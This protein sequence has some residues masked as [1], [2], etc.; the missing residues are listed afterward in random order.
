MKNNYSHINNKNL[1]IGTKKG[2]TLIEMLVVM[3]ILVVLVSIV[4]VAINPK[5]NF[6]EA[7]NTKRRSDLL[8]LSNAITQYSIDNNGDLV[9]GISDEFQ[10]ISSDNLDICNDLVTLYIA[11]MPFDPETGYFNNC[12]DY[13]TDY[14]VMQTTDNRLFLSTNNP[15]ID[16]I[17]IVK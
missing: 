12:N 13:N 1:S 9:S 17:L 4:L 3:G 8:T 6:D 11:E 2:F 14:N 15:D 10:T 5:K 7:N 16:G